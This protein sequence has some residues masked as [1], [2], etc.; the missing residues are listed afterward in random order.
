MAF[1][2]TVDEVAALLGISRPRVYQLIK[3]E[4]LAAEKIGG[5][6]FVDGASVKERQD[7][8]PSPGRPSRASTAEGKIYSLMNRDHKVLDFTYDES[9]ARFV[10]ITALYDVDRAP[11]GIVSQRGKRTSPDAL[12]RWWEHRCIPRSRDGLETK[13][14]QLG[15]ERLIDLPFRSL[16]LSL[17]DQ[18]WVQPASSDARWRDVSFFVNDF[19]ETDVIGKWLDE[20]GLDSPANTS[21]GELSKKW[22]CRKGS[23]VLLKGGGLLDQEPYNEVVATAL[24]RRLLEPDEYVPYTIETS[25]A[26][27]ASICEVFVSEEEEYIPAYYVKQL[28]R[29]PN[30]HNDLQ[31]YLD[32]CEHLGV[33]NAKTMLE[34]MIVCDDILGNYDRHWRNFGIIRNVETLRYRV[35]PLFDTGSSLWCNKPERALASG[36]Y[37]FTTKPFYEDANRQLRLVDDYSWLNVEALDGFA[38]E[39]GAIL[40]DNDAL[41]TRIPY[42]QE[43]IQARIDRI[44]RLL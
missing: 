36:D 9:R 29:Q 7:A 5:M 3:E 15:I 39:A 40:A 11:F 37:S 30:H 22:V 44:L 2:Y 26:G 13:L 41:T 21:E 24:Y 25:D 33:V 35:A 43:A 34:K 42:I 6:W 1:R 31:H 8:K 17:S 10:D 14:Q 27:A 20:V 38:E 18:Y 19:A 28:L 4:K 23:R 12:K 16:G 32:C